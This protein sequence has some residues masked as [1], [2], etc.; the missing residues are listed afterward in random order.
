MSID[1]AFKE[2]TVWCP[3]CME[4]KFE[5]YR[6][7]AGSAGVYHNATLPAGRNEKYCQ[8]GAPLARKP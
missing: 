2:A 8:C 4:D 5:V 7:P 3:R 6:L 1:E